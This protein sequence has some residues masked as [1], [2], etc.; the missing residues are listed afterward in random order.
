MLQGSVGV[1]L[2][3]YNRQHWIISRSWGEQKQFLKAQPSRSFAKSLTFFFVDYQ[4]INSHDQ[5]KRSKVPRQY[6]RFA[7]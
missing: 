4:T 2:E 6:L 7:M 3:K 1:F 5:L